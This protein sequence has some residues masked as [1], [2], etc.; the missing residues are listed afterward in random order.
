MVYLSVGCPRVF[1]TIME[2]SGP[3]MEISGP[4]M[5]ILGP[6]TRIEKC[7][8]ETVPNRSKPFQNR[9]RTVPETT[10]DAAQPVSNRSEMLNG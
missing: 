3:I 2:I 4:I 8:A 1:Q 7:S 5:D 9:F 10:N 6:T